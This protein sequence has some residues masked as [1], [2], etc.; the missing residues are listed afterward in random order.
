M[1]SSFYKNYLGLLPMTDEEL[2]RI[3][4]PRMELGVHTTFKCAQVG[5]CLG[6]LVPALYCGCVTKLPIRELHHCTS[7]GGAYGLAGGAALGP[8]F[9]SAFL[10]RK[11]FTD[12]E[13]YERCHRLRVNKGQMRID[14]SMIVGAGVGSAFGGCQQK[15]LFG[16]CAGGVSGIV[17]MTVINQGVKFANKKK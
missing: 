14:R 11:K 10:W 13:C 16:A 2:R 6:M 3:T 8:V 5:L 4:A 12:D 17:L 7:L 15:L 1:D 9:T